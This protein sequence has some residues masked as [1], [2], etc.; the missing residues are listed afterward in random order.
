MTSVCNV[1]RMVVAII[2]LACLAL[3][4]LAREN[5]SVSSKAVKVE[6]QPAVGTPEQ[7]I[8]EKHTSTIR[9]HYVKGQDPQ[10]CPAIVCCGGRMEFHGAAMN[11]TWMKLVATAKAGATEIMLEDVVTGWKPGDRVILTA[12]TRQI[13][14]KKTFQP[15]V[16]DNTQTEERIIKEISVLPRVE[17][18]KVSANT[19]IM[20][21]EPLKFEHA[22]DGD[23]RGEVANLSR[24]VV[25]E[26]AKTESRGHTMYHH[27]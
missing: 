8:N 9:L 19:K 5:K 7:P 26:S 23:Y 4:M 22:G 27:G 25:I 16:K 14:A 1:I 21:T 10:S 24:N 15:S 11:R 6:E 20:L 17:N 12:T 13:K 2:L 18:E 3:P